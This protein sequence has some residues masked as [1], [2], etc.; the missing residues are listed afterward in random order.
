MVEVDLTQ[1]RTGARVRVH[2][3][4]P[5]EEEMGRWSAQRS[6]NQLEALGRR[7]D[8]GEWTAADGS[9]G[10]GQMGRNLFF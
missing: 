3:L 6:G 9:R 5:G 2:V 1:T 7:L 4:L 8:G 10:G